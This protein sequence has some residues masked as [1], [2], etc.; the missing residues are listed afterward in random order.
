MVGGGAGTGCQT[1]SGAGV[2]AAGAGG[3]GVGFTGAGAHTTFAVVLGVSA[4]GL[5]AGA[6]TTAGAGAL[7]PRSCT[8]DES[9]LP[10]PDS[11][12]SPSPL[13]LSEARCA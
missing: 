8:F 3:G 10:G 1:T 12:S 2:G 5:A 6:Q 13:V 7:M 11:P 4:A 9:D